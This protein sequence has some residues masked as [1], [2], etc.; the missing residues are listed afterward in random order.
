MVLKNGSAQG[1]VL[2]LVGV[3]EN[4]SAEGGAV[5]HGVAEAYHLVLAVQER[6]Q[7]DRDA[8]GDWALS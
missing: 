4:T 2:V 1:W 8:C 6:V 3:P 7:D 5:A